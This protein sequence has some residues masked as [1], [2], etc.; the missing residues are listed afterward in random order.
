MTVRGEWHAT[1]HVAAA[2]GGELYVSFYSGSPGYPAWIA[3]HRPDGSLDASFG[4]GGFARLP[5]PVGPE[6][7]SRSLPRRIAD[8]VY[9]TSA[10]IV[11]GMNVPFGPA[12]SFIRLTYDGRVD[13]S[14]PRTPVLGSDVAIGGGRGGEVA[15]V[16]RATLMSGLL[17]NGTDLVRGP[18]RRRANPVLR[19]IGDHIGALVVERR[20]HVT[21]AQAR[22]RGSPRSVAYPGVELAR[23]TPALRPDRTF[24]TRGTA[25]LT[26]RPASVAGMT[27]D[28]RGRLLALLHGAEISEGREDIE[29][30]DAPTGRLV[31][32]EG[33]VPLVRLRSARRARGSVRVRVACVFPAQE[34]CSGTVKVLGARRTVLGSRRLRLRTGRAISMRVRL[35][36]RARGRVVAEARIL[37]GA[38]LLSS[39]RRGVRS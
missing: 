9:L 3:R 1:Q 15:W 13:E 17:R 5:A 35:R 28:R 7:D 36:R 20:G 29:L 4:D 34:V 10:G 22:R 6:L 23:Q 18:L 32:L 33:G 37:D 16:D 39:A 2:P 19:S 31:R 8:A 24:G 21:F 30:F 14:F 26:R 25:L 12:A 11:L 27:V 38:G